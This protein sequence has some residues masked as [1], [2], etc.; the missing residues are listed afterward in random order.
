MHGDL[1]GILSAPGVIPEIL[2]FTPFKKS[3]D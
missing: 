2:T 3:I 1:P